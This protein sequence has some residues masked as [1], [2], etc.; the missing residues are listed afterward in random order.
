MLDRSAEILTLIQQGRLSPA[1]A[2]LKLW[3]KKDPGSAPAWHLLGVVQLHR[4]DYNAAEAALQQALQIRPEDAYARNNRSLVLL[5]LGRAEESR[6][7]AQAAI[8]RQANEPGFLANLG[9]AC[10]ALRD[11]VAMADAFE[12][13]LALGADLKECGLAIAKAR[14]QLQHWAEARAALA[15]L[16]LTD[17]DVLTETL[18]LA[19]SSGD[20]ATIAR[21]EARCEGGWDTIAGAL[22]KA[23]QFEPAED[24]YQRHLQCHP[25]DASARYLLEALTGR[26]AREANAAYVSAVFDDA[27]EQFDQ[28]LLGPL[29]YQAPAWLTRHLPKWAP[30]NRVWDFGC[31]TGLAAGPIKQFYPEADLIGF[32]LSAAMLEQARQK[33]QYRA[34]HQLD[35]RDPHLFDVLP[36]DQQAPDLVLLMDV[37]IYV[38]DASRWLANAMTKMPKGCRWVITLEQGHHERIHKQGRIQ[39]D[40]DELMAALPPHRCLYDETAP[41]RV[42]A[43]KTVTGRWLVLVS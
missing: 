26:V 27:A 34:L 29:D 4:H 20:R 1:L 3:L 35:I 11:Y 30:V 31:G 15:L 12:R 36:A 10:E 25:G 17:P 19:H 8:A 43:G 5:R 6:R 39:H 33:G 22:V 40:G 42:E 41:L 32:D 24:Y 13:A 37:L 16:S 9:Y 7:E 14:R 2:R 38:P 23:G 21:T 28:H 18:V